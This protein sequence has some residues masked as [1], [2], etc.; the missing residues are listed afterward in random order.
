MDTQ[1]KSY[2]VNVTLGTWLIDAENAELAEEAV[3][4]L[5]KSHYGEKTAQVLTYDDA[6]EIEN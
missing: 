5:V 3:F 4:D 6:Q 2:R 1:L